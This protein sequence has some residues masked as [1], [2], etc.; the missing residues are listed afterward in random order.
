MQKAR[1]AFCMFF[2]FLEKNEGS[3]TLMLLYDPVK[4]VAYFFKGYC[5]ITP[6]NYSCQL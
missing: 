1:Q 2:S 5:K 6:A 4:L 3:I